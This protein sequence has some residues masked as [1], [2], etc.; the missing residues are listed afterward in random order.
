MLEILEKIEKAEDSSGVG[1]Y[2]TYL[3]DD[4]VVKKCN[5][6]DYEGYVPCLYHEDIQKHIDLD[7]TLLIPKMISNFTHGKHGY[8]V[9]ERIV[10]LNDSYRK[11]RAEEY[12]GTIIERNN[13]PRDFEKN[14][15]ELRMYLEDQGYGLDDEHPGNFGYKGK[16]F[17]CLD[18]GCIFR[19]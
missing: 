1:Y 3:L 19:S 4:V 9:V 15:E 5:L 18:E 7:D 13:W 14:V 6:D 2:T 17:M 8:L 12:Y 16:Y 11:G 10:C